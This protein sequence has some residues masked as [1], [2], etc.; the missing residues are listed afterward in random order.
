MAPAKKLSWKFPLKNFVFLKIETVFVAILALLVFL[1]SFQKGWFY[2]VVT[3]IIFLGIYVFVSYVVQKI[4]N[5][6]EQYHV[7]DTHF[8]VTRKTRHTVQKD[9]IPLKDVKSHKLSKNFLGGYLLT[10]KKKHLLFFNS[11]DELD[12]FDRHLNKHYD[13]RN[14]R[15]VTKKSVAKKK[16]VKKAAPKKKTVKRRR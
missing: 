15:K 5:V 6:E 4:R 3:T 14:K 16:V 8:H 1:L 11:K 13:S 12:K 7:T 2:A 10:H 9:V